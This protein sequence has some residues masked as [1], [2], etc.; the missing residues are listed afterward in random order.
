VTDRAEMDAARTAGL[1]ARH[2][3]RE[4][5]AV[6]RQVAEEIALA[7]EA[8]RDSAKS[9]TEVMAMS[10]H[11]ALTTAADVARQIGAEETPS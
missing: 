6:R 3:T 5:R 9:L 2:E 10:I 11:A 7:I 8:R 4:A 1:R